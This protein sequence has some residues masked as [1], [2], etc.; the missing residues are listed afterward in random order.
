MTTLTGAEII[1]NLPKS[2]GDCVGM[3]DYKGRIFIACQFAMFEFYPMKDYAAKGRLLLVEFDNLVDAPG[4][5]IC[6]TAL[7]AILAL[8]DSRAAMAAIKQIA[9]DALEEAGYPLTLS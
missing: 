3:L 6:R 8:D 2:A 1:G 7:Q 9:K 5:V 4:T